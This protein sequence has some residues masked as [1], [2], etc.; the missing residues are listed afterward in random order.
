MNRRRLLICAIAVAFGAGSHAQ[1]GSVPRAGFDLHYRVQG[2]GKPIVFLAGGPGFDVGYLE[3]AAKLFPAGYQRVFLEQRGTGKS[4]P[5]K[6]DAD[7]MSL[8]LAIEDLEALRQHLG[9]EKLTLAGH[10]WGGMLAMAYT[11]SHPDRVERLILIGSGG[12]TREFLDYYEDNI[13]ARLHSEDMEARTYWDN[14]AKRGVDADKA[15]LESIK[16]IYP[17]FFFDRTQGLATAATRPDGSYHADTN[18]LMMADI[19]KGYD[20][21]VGLARVTSPVLI[22]QGRQDPLGDA[23]AEEI[24]ALLGASVIRYINHCGHF[25]WIEQPENFKG[26]I[27]EFLSAK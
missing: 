10:S 14:A 24:H 17:A 19:E 9:L 27:A 22:I 6:M 15:A 2:S 8:R 16:A 18:A 5:H 23:T 21:R 1:T 20:L 3:D 11:A 12:P 25:P 4:R 13:D 26:I 7:N